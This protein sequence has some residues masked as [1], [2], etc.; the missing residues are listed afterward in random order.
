MPTF[1][2]LHNDGDVSMNIDFSDGGPDDVAVL[3]PSI[4]I[5]SSE[6]IEENKEPDCIYHGHLRDENDVA[7]SLNGCP[8]SDTFEVHI[9]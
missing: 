7:V 3:K 6:A 2:W 9:Y 1:R 5:Y 8:E 4:S